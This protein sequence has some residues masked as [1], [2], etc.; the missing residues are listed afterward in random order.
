MHVL[1]TG[2]SGFIGSHLVEHHLKK[3]DQVHS[4]DDLSTGSIDNA[5]L[6]HG[7]PD[8]L[9]SEADI[10]TWP[11]L[12]RAVA[13]ADRIYHMAAVVGV[14]RVLKNPVQVLATNIA[15]CERILRA[16][17]A[18]SWS[19][20]ILIASS[21]EVYGKGTDE[22]DEDAQLTIESSSN[23]RWNYAISKLADEVFGLSYARENNGVRVVIARLFN[24]IGPRQSGRYGMVVPRFVQQAIAG[25]PI[26]VFGDGS[27]S[28]CFCDVRDTVVALDLL[29]SDKSNNGEIFNVGNRQE[30]TIKDLAEHIRKLTGS[31]SKLEFIAYEQAY[32]TD[33]ED[34]HRRCASFSKLRHTTGFRAIHKLDDTILDIVA[35]QRL[36]QNVTSS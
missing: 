2:G 21:S 33:F 28:R 12:E 25:D 20:K 36:K 1:V 23:P 10:L 8:F 9:F 17:K 18:S 19:P 11:G 16:A 27:Q 7:S 13:W 14:Y 22:F 5:A 24:T 32:G 34:I 4:V 6:F 35:E 15:G 31:T 30:I 29:A 26:T 3:G